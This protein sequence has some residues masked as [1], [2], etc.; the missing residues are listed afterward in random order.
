MALSNRCLHTRLL[1]RMVMVVLLLS[2][3]MVVLLLS[4]A[5]V[6]LLLSVAMVVLLE[7]GERLFASIFF[8]R[9]GSR[10]TT[11]LAVLSFGTTPR[12][13]IVTSTL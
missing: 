6:V 5:M 9:G 8:I 11:L 7:M 3:A 12:A 1:L 13:I 2:M 4:V 10:P